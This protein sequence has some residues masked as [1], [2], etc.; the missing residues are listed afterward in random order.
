M[1]LLRKT[2]YAIRH[3]AYALNRIAGPVREWTGYD[4]T[5]WARVVMYR[6]LFG[7]VRTLGPASMSALEISPDGPSSPWRGL[8][9]ATYEGVE[10]PDFDICRD[11]LDNQFDLVIADQ[12]FEHLLWPY[13]AARN[14]HAMLKIGGRFIVTTPFL[15]RVH[16]NPVDCSRWTETGLKHLL[17]EAGFELGAIETGSWGNLGCVR[18]NL[19]AASWARVGWGRRMDRE[20]GYP[21][22]VWAI[23]RK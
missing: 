15:I 2:I 10:H 8:G 11:R 22:S 5:Q 4:A 9:F 19:T 20:A 7:L 21:V 1:S 6:E 16:E 17:A 13:R 14:V 18:A 23:A 12:V 3:P